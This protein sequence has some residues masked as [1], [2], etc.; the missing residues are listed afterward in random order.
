MSV[1][2]WLEGAEGQRAVAYAHGW[3][4]GSVTV[5]EALGQERFPAFT[6]RLL[7]LATPATK[8]LDHDQ[9]IGCLEALARLG[10]LTELGETPDGER[11][12]KAAQRLRVVR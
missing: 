10:V 12:F 3:V 8:R 9:A 6:A 5:A 1:G 7:V 11:L 2:T 4:V